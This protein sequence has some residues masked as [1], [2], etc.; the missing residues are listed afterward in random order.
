MLSRM[1][2]AV[3][4]CAAAT[5]AVA[6]TAA[7]RSV[8]L[9]VRG[10]FQRADAGFDAGAAEIVAYDPDTHRAFVVNAQNATVDVIDVQNLNQPRLVATIDV[11]PS[12]LGLVA[13]S[14]DVAN[15][16]LAVALQAD[17][18]TDPGFVALYSTSEY[19]APLNVVGVGFLPD[20]V[21][22]SP[23]GRYVLSRTTIIRS[24]RK[25]PSA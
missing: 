19:S 1:T 7:P 3:A 25:G 21:T 9:E 12:G 5:T 4:A 24:T 18:K 6:A 11:D 15:G 2:L 20:M 14:V 13:N 16:I 22:F 10:T 17:P 23:D 8:S